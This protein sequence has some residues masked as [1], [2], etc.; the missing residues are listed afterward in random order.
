MKAS[1][2]TGQT[3]QGNG[4]KEVR[5]R[6]RHSTEDAARTPKKAALPSST[7]KVATKNFA[8]LRTTNMDTDALGT[9]SNSAEEA[10]PGKQGRPPPIALTSETNLILLQKQLKILAKQTFEFRSTKN[11][12]RVVTM[13]M[14]DYQSVKAFFETNNLSYYTFYPKSENPIKAEILHL[15]TNTPAE[16]IAVGLVDLSFG[17]Y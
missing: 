9:D 3:K 17:L 2:Q 6:K 15:P 16:D 7:E 12:T 5:S 14:V 13:D 10:V 8:P 1:T 4:F 11:G